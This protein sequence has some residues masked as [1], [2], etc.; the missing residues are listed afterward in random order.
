MRSF[1]Q[2]VKPKDDLNVPDAPSIK[3]TAGDGKIDYILM[4]GASDDV[5]GYTI[6]YTPAGGETSTKDVTALTGTLEGLTN[7]T[8][9]TVTVIAHN[10][11][12]DS[13]ASGAVKAT[14]KAIEPTK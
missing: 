1:Q 6:S 2:R 14:P 3:L 13:A 8:E 9:Y 10:A 5:T 11:K 12:G 4:A 7:D